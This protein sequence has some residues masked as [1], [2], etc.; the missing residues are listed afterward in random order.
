MVSF[1][2]IKAQVR[3]WV[4]VCAGVAVLCGGTGCASMVEGSVQRLH[5]ETIGAQDAV[6]DVFVA[7]FRHRVYPPQDIQIMRNSEDIEIACVA[8]DNRRQSM[9]LAPVRQKASNWNALHGWVAGA[10]YDYFS[11]AMF[12]YP[13][14]VAVDF[15][16]IPP[17]GESLPAHHNSDRSPPRKTG[18]ES[19][20][21]RFPALDSDRPPV[22]PERLYPL[23]TQDYSDEASFAPSP[24]HQ[25]APLPLK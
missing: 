10:G 17:V 18:L 2:D 25:N 1:F 9:Q 12:A 24:K 21:P 5:V 3:G 16:G 8:P 13:E 23:E 14:F 4:G 19:Y 7:G 15:T 11:G 6:C 22:T 20:D